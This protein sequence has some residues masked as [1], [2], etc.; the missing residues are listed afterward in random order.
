M[1]DRRWSPKSWRTPR[2]P[3]RGQTGNIYD[4]LKEVYPDA[5]GSVRRRPWWAK[6]AY[7]RRWISGR[8]YYAIQPEP[9]GEKSAFAAF[10][11]EAPFF[12]LLK[13]EK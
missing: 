12:K 7:E 8:A 4:I 5:S 6:L 1:R 13:K 2:T 9:T 10:Y 11:E 3:F